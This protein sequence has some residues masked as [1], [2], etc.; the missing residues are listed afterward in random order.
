MKKISLL[1]VF[2]L[3]G[4]LLSCNSVDY[5]IYEEVVSYFYSNYSG[6]S[7][8]GNTPIRFVKHRDGY[9]VEQIGSNGEFENRQ[10]LWTSKTGQFL[11][12]NYGK[13][14]DKA[15]RQIERTLSAWDAY[16]FDLYPYYGYMNWEN[17][18]I[19]ELSGK[20]MLSD[21]N[22][23]A[24]GRAYSAAATNLLNNNSGFG[25]NAKSFELPERGEN[26]LS[27]KQ[28]D[29]Y[30]RYSQ[31]SI[32]QFQKLC[33][34][35]P[36][37][38]TIVGSICNKTSNE[39]M[40]S[41]LNILIYQN[42]EEALKEIQKPLYDPIYTD[43]A[44]NYLNSCEPNAILFTHGDNDT[45]PLLYVQ[46]YENFRK[47]VFVVNMSLLNSV[48][49]A[50]FC[51]DREILNT[52]P[53]KMT[54]SPKTYE[55]GKLAWIFCKDSYNFYAPLPEI[56]SLIE[57]KNQLIYNEQ[58][59]DFPI[60]PTKKYK[61]VFTSG[62]S[63]SFK[64]PGNSISRGDI[65]ALDII[66][67]NI[68]ERP[69]YILN[70]RNLGLSDNTELN[71]LAFKFTPQESTRK[72]ALM[73]GGLNSG[74]TFRL[75]M[76]DLHRN[77][78]EMPKKI[79]LFPYLRAFSEL[80]NYYAMESQNDTCRQIINRYFELFPE[81]DF[82]LSYSIL[83]MLKSAYETGLRDESK[84]IS[85][86][87]TDIIWDYINNGQITEKDNH[88]STYVVMEMLQLANDYDNALID[89]LRN[90]QEKLSNLSVNS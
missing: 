13:G 44:K 83:P 12:I 35:S 29:L 1:F 34:K 73:D 84:K 81:I 15:E 2:L 57:G 71:G 6:Q 39:H 11:S 76:E 7:S 54:L 47:D 33:D 60:L 53:V 52:N 4:I 8:L 18:V 45:Y 51:R 70:N 41:F 23:Y 64:L 19:K 55:G 20:K 85:R 87:L 82:N 16:L 3:S 17:D 5:P 14:G 10:L 89:E 38:E 25:N 46:A 50:N 80:A 67:S 43:L 42:E 86:Q 36:D 40:T 66:Q 65:L 22:L 26:L 59:P 58:Y 90:L 61:I 49:Y 56:F 68:S 24:L 27:S 32:E 63:I 28:L 75:I 37:Y 88:L 72:N 21:D 78:Q 77:T 79:E 30:R 48:S 69:I 31:N 9:Y 62:D 74:E